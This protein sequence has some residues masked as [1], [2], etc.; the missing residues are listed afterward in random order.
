[1]RWLKFVIRNV[2]ITRPYGLLFLYHCYRYSVDYFKSH[3]GCWMHCENNVMRERILTHYN[4]HYFTFHY[5]LEQVSNFS[6]TKLCSKYKK[7]K[8]AFNWLFLFCGVVVMMVAIFFTYCLHMCESI[9]WVIIGSDYSLCPAPHLTIIIL[10]WRHN[11]RD[12]VS[13]HRPPDCLLNR[14]FKGQIK[15]NIKAS[16]HWP[17]WGEF[18]GDRWIPRT[19]GQ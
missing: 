1:M 2:P 19:K 16:R 7:W 5:T 14:L 17:L 10:Q 11:R 18:T 8:T 12:G 13:N 9:I 3:G 4:Q 15:E 6:R